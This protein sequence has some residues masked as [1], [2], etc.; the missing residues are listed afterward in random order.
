MLQAS[1]VVLLYTL[2]LPLTGT[3]LVV[4]LLGLLCNPW[5]K[6]T[7]ETSITPFPPCRF[8]HPCLGQMMHPL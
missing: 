7:P 8:S 4:W 2:D 6:L 1:S 3:Q 5:W